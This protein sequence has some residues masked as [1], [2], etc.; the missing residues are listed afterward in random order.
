[1]PHLLTNFNI[2]KYYQNEPRFN[3]VYYRGNLPK[4]WR[5]GAYIWSLDEY[6]DADASYLEYT[7]TIYWFD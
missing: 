2:Q 3:G 4:K 1:M 7:Q 5:M 6:A